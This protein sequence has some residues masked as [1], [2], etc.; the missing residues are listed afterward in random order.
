M[1]QLLFETPWLENE[2]QMKIIVLQDE[3]MMLLVQMPM[4][5]Q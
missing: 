4:S 3:I 1:V 5:G 2:S